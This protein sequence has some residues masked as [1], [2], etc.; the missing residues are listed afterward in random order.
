MSIVEPVKLKND[1]RHAVTQFGV[2]SIVGLIPIGDDRQLER[3]DWIVCQTGRGL[4]IGCVR[5]IGTN[6]SPENTADQFAGHFVRM[7]TDSDH[8]AQSR[9]DDKKHVGLEACSQWLAEQGSTEVLLDVDVM[10]DGQ[11]LYFH[12]LGDNDTF[13]PALNDQLVEIYDRV[14]GIR[15][16]TQTVSEGCGPDCGSDGSGCHTDGNCGSGGSKTGCSSCGLKSSC[17]TPKRK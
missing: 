15:Q 11:R 2:M 1:Q 8:M 16:F 5:S 12:F 17:H 14:T 7:A 9:L 13:D 6:R 3:G 4:E 10:L